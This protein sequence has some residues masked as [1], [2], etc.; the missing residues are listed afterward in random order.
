MILFKLIEELKLEKY[1]FIF[2][3]IFII[4]IYHVYKNIYSCKNNI[5]KMTSISDDRIAEAVKQYYLSD[6][7]LKTMATTS[8]KIQTEGLKFNGNIS[9]NGSIKAINEITSNNYSLSGTNTNINNAMESFQIQQDNLRRQQ[10]AQAEQR[11]QQELAEAERRRQQELADAE[12]RRRQ[13]QANADAAAAA[14]AQ[15]RQQELAEQAEAE[16]QKQIWQNFLNRHPGTRCNAIYGRCG[17]NDGVDYNLWISRGGSC[18][19]YERSHW[20]CSTGCEWAQG[21]DQGRCS[22]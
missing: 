16:R 9:V 8:I 17:D 19:R 14:A 15:R 21:R 2:I 3:C 20:R 6:D 1:V 10:L 22:W 11:R 5:E 4:L 13:E 12:Q 7:F 18:P